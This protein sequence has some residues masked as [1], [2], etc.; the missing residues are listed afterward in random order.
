MTRTPACSRPAEPFSPHD[1][2]H[3]RVSLLHSQ[4]W[5]WAKIGAYVGQRNLA[6]TANAYTHVLID[7][8]EVDY[9]ELI[10]SRPLRAATG[11]PM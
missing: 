7:E 10:A 2:R 5:S 3:R 8:A 1:L 11:I 4:G 9:A 6:V